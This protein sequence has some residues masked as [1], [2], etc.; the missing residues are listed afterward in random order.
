MPRGM[1]FRN[2]KLKSHILLSNM[3]PTLNQPSHKMRKNKQLFVLLDIHTL[4]KINIK[5]LHQAENWN[6]QT[7]NWQEL[8]WKTAKD[9]QASWKIRRWGSVSVL[10]KPSTEM[11]SSFRKYFKAA[12]STGLAG[13]PRCLFMYSKIPAS[14]YRFIHIKM[15]VC[16]S[17][18]HHLSTVIMPINWP[19]DHFYSPL[20]TQTHIHIMV[21]L[22]LVH[23]GSF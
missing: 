16:K 1:A 13:S 10:K 8:L 2:S 6:C 14:P 11:S 15:F 18:F 5:E 17:Q 4:V 12:L 3:P 23:D 20:S 21:L 9:L 7:L 19:S 22:I